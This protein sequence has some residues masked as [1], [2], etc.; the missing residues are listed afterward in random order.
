MKYLLFLILLVAI[1]IIAGCVSEDKN[2][3]I[4]LTLT[5][6]QTTITLTPTQTQTVQTIAYELVQYEDKEWGFR[7]NYDKRWNITR[8]FF[9]YPRFDSPS[10][11]QWIIIQISPWYNRSDG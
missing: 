6:T 4:T 11:N 7:I 1:L 2:T 9:I 3:I 10:G 8:R 5:P